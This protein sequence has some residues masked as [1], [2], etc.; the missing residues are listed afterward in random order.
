MS[1]KK[2]P[3]VL[4]ADTNSLTTLSTAV[5]PSSYQNQ[6]MTSQEEA[7]LA[8]APLRNVGVCFSGGGSRALS[9]AM[10][11]YRGLTN[12]KDKKGVTW[13]DRIGTISSVSGGTWASSIY[14]YLPEKFS[15]DEL[16]GGVAQPSQLT[17]DGTG[18]AALSD[19]NVNSM[20]QVPVRLEL[21][22]IVELIIKLRE[23]GFTDWS[24]MWRVMVGELVLKPYGLYEADS[25]YNPTT[26]YAWQ[27]DWFDKYIWPQ[28]TS[29]NSNQFHFARNRWPWLTMNTSLIYNKEPEELLPVMSHMFRAGINGTFPQSGQSGPV[30]GGGSIQPFAF[31]SQYVS[32]PEVGRATVAS[33]RPFSLSDIVGLSSVAFA[34]SFAEHDKLKWLDPD[35]LVPKYDY[36]PVVNGG[37]QGSVYEFADGGSL[38][39]TGV[40]NL[41]ASTLLKKIVVFVNAE[42]KVEQ[43]AGYTQIPGSIPP[44][45]GYQPLEDGFFEK[46]YTPYSDGGDEAYPLMKN[47]QVFDK[48]RFQELL[49]GMKAATDNFQNAAIFFQKDLP[50]VNNNVFGVKGN[51]TVDVLW[52]CN[53]KVKAWEGQLEE[54]IKLILDVRE[55]PE[56]PL[57]N[58]PWYGTVA[59]LH[60]TERQVNMLAHLSCWTV[61][62][63]NY[64][65]EW[66]K[67]FD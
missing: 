49:D 33:P 20:G 42:I 48:G 41:L 27:S 10:G 22:G 44:L 23:Q 50:V 18:P 16:L 7:L 36:F 62:S 67:I 46:G 37:S 8:E 60:L 9:A 55:V 40:N 61:M 6:G 25:E 53:N 35:D 47:N 32:T 1:D 14:I 15:Y 12:K 57:W 19:L 52:V 17:W 28:N 3:P 2:H 66:E 43:V 51:R 59:Q 56:S 65:S 63:D 64:S 38:E 29:L 54:A 26:Y 5:Y 39:N 4:S 58:F 30:V 45:F 31:A 11:Q 13:M 34:A 24:Q 21:T